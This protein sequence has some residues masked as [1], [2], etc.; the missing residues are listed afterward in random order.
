LANLSVMLCAFHGLITDDSLQPKVLVDA[1]VGAGLRAVE[2]ML[3]NLDVAPVPWQEVL[4]LCQ[5]AGLKVS[6]LDIGANLV[7]NSLEERTEALRTVE[8]ALDLCVEMNCPLGLIY[9]STPAPDMS[10][11]DGRKIY[12]QGLA[13]CAEM[14]QSRHVTACI[15]DYGGSTAFACRSDHV[16][17]VVTGAGPEVRVVWDN[18][19]FILADELPMHAYDVL[20]DLA[21]H[22]HIK[23][24]ALDETDQASLKSTAGKAYKGTQ[25]GK[26]DTQVAECVAALKRD[27]YDGW[28]SLEVGGPP[29]EQMI[30]GAEFVK[31][32]WA[33]A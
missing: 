14:A 16:R 10:N 32:V 28:L 22:V 13:R 6:C 5:E 25:I 26:G 30:A 11:E 27:D 33:E 3:S 2:P 24:F 12:S 4:D 17:E 1:I 20:R 31:R 9:G 8:R 15:E 21:V 23:D 19:N 7:G 29:V 18:G